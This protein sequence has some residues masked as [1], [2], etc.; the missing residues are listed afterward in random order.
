MQCPCK[1][2]KG[3]DE[4]VLYWLGCTGRLSNTN[5]DSFSGSCC[6][7][8]LSNTNPDSF[9]GSYWSFASDVSV[10]PSPENVHRSTVLTIRRPGV[11]EPPR[12]ERFAG[13]YR[14]PHREK[15]P[16]VCFPRATQVV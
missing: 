11:T 16:R 6:T 1:R 10:F 3:F 7:G 9:L 15:C 4:A 14:G 8:R 2:A 13:L 5:P 12:K